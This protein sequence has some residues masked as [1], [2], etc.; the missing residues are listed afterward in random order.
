MDGQTDEKPAQPVIGFRWY[1]ICTEPKNGK[2]NAALYKR[3]SYNLS[4]QYCLLYVTL[5]RAGA[6]SA[7]GLGGRASSSAGARLVTNGAWAPHGGARMCTNT[8]RPWFRLCCKNF[9]ESL[10]LGALRRD[11]YF[12]LE[13][14]PRPRIDSDLF[15]LEQYILEQRKH[16]T[17]GGR[18]NILWYN[19]ASTLD[20]DLGSDFRR[21][22]VFILNFP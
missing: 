2:S 10:P 19:F 22:P 12:V 21:K 17:C 18:I 1:F 4:G 5:S 20:L 16:T 9:V 15:F 11:C 14:A 6:R 13:V 8:P 7:A 3:A